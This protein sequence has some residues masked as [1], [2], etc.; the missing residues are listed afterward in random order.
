M[1]VCFWL[2]SRFME[3][4][5]AYFTRYLLA[6]SSANFYIPTFLL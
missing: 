6:E 5:R 1:P 4:I 3:G 2:G